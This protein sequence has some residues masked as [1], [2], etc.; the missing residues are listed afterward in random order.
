[1][2]SKERIFDWQFGRN[3]H[4]DGRDPF[5]IAELGPGRP[6]AINGLMPARVRFQGEG[7]IA[8]WSCDTFVDPEV[9]AFGVATELGQ[10][11]SRTAP[12]V[13]ELSHG[14]RD[15]PVSGRPVPRL[16]FHAAERG[17][18]GA[19]KTACSRVASLRA[20][21]M[22]SR[23]CEVTSGPDP[24]TSSQID[25][26]WRFCAKGYPRAIERDAAYLRWKFAEHPER[27]YLW[28]SLRSRHQLEGLV[29]GRHDP[30]ES[31]IVD[32]C[33]PAGDVDLMTELMVAAVVDLTGRGTQRVR[34]ETTHVPMI[35]ALRRAGFLECRPVTALQVRA[36]M[37]VSDPLADWFVMTGDCDA[38]MIA[39][40]KGLR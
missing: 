20:F 25:E 38:D 17:P 6:V 1:M 7:F 31:A 37:T 13:L 14:D 40:A 27:A 33:G 10:R 32:Y 15:S 34:C 2:T 28:Y 3:P 29:I 19:V 22:S 24:R 12:L 16:V 4:D 36:N 30:Y 23:R 5:L 18:I 39:G 26:L 8:C 9:R 35:A 21:G 11:V